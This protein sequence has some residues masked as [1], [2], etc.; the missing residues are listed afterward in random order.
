MLSYPVRSPEFNCQTA[1]EAQLPRF[2]P[3][4]PTT[5]IEMSS[6]FPLPVSA[7]PSHT[8]HPLWPPRR[9]L[10]R[11]LPAVK[12]AAVRCSV[13][14]HQP[15]LGYSD[16]HS[17]LSISSVERRTFRGECLLAT[18][19][20]STGLQASAR[21]AA[22]QDCSKQWAPGSKT[23]G[24]Y[25]ALLPSPPRQGTFAVKRILFWV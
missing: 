3:L 15:D 6:W 25:H 5:E 22:S 18:P 2:P 16:V 9:L 1:P 23:D 11:P 19:A 4:F 8:S 24:S 21:R 12:E 20:Q 13:H 7:T 10:P 14:P 17:L